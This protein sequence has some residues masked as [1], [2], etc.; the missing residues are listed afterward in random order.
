MASP[1]HDRDVGRGGRASGRDRRPDAGGRDRDLDRRGRERRP[2]ARSRMEEFARKISYRR[3]RGRGPLSARIAFARG[4][5]LVEVFFFVV[6]LVV[7]AIPEG[8]PVALTVVLSV[9]A[10][11]MAKRSVIV[12][13]ITAVESLGSCTCIASD[14]TGTLTVNDR[15]SRWSGSPRLAPPRDR[16]GV[17]GRGDGRGGQDRGLSARGARPPVRFGTAGPRERGRPRAGRGPVARILG[18]SVDIGVSRLRARPRARP[19]GGPGPGA[20]AHRSRTS[21]NGG[22]P[23]PCRRGGPAS[24]GCRDE[25]RSRALLPDCTEMATPDGPVPLDRGAGERRP[26]SSLSDG[27]FRVIAVAEGAD[28]R[29]AMVGGAAPATDPA[30]ARR[31]HRPRPAGRGRRGRGVPGGRDPRGDGDRRPPGHGPRD[32]PAPSVSPARA[33]DVVTG[34]DLDESARSRCRPPDRVGSATVFARVAPLQK[35]ASS[36]PCSGSGTSWP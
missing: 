22:T 9:A 34:A 29:R 2:P 31:V 32:R 35:L 36:R 6:A 1:E 19:R 10:S 18:D 7:A 16:D 5:P 8:L 30:R 15:P 17:R 28:S 25:G 26:S 11:R 27:G 21:P 3:R 23:P 24:G 14:K 13:R 20:S 4:I 33:E 12:R